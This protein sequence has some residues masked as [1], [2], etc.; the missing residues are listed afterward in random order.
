MPREDREM[1]LRTEPSIKRHRR[2]MLGRDDALAPLAFP[3][4]P[5]HGRDLTG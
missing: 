1:A 4:V 5:L 3:E 2:R